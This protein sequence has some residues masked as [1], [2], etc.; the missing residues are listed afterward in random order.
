[1]YLSQSCSSYSLGDNTDK[2]VMYNIS[3]NLHNIFD[4]LPTDAI[5]WVK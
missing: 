5:I 1:M 2:I 3:A 4:L